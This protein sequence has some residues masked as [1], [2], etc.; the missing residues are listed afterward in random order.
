MTFLAFSNVLS[1]LIERSDDGYAI[2]S[3]DDILLCCNQAFCDF[4]GQ[5][6]DAMI[7]YSFSDIMR[8]CFRLQRGPLLQTDDIEAWLVRANQ[9]R[10][11]QPYRLFEVDL[12][13]GRWCLMSEQL[14]ADG[15]L[16]M[17]HKDMTRQKNLE[18][19]LNQDTRQLTSLAQT[20]ELTRIANRRGF[21]A[22]VQRAVESCVQR[23][24]GMAFLLFDLDHFKHI[25]DRYGHHTGDDVLR[26]MARKVPSSLRDEDLFGRIGG[27]E[28]GVFLSNVDAEQAR[29]IAERIRQ[30]IAAQP[31]YDDISITLSIGVVHTH[32]NIALN[33]LYQYADQA[34]YQAK[35]AGRNLSVLKQID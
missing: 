7:G 24:T 30:D 19:Q 34:L 11:S 3:P 8:Q 31:L 20:D 32:T 14:S 2:L 21:I 26:R 29:L 15:H 4:F 33:E 25:N 22:A 35:A 23:Q 1:E 10:R 12:L 18:L 9:R 16:L 13:D 6:R 17:Q 5:P 27:E 28:F